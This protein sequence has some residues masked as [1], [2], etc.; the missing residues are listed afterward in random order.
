MVDGHRA[1]EAD[2]GGLRRGV[3][4]H[5][6]RAQCSDRGDIHDRTAI[7]ARNHRR[8]GVLGIEEH[9]LDIDAHDPFPLALGLLGD[10]AE[11]RNPDVVVENIKPPELRDCG[12]HHRR[13]LILVGE[14]SLVGNRRA[15]LRLDHPDRALGE[16]K[17]SVHDKHLGARARKENGRRTPI[18]DAVACRSAARDDGDLSI[19]S[20]ICLKTVVHRDSP[21][22][23]DARW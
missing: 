4:G 9:R 21:C 2:D 3:G 20:E 7:A 11:A 17:R 16:F 19:Q 1:G 18:A 6:A 23:R 12:L 13:A 22:P 14:V 15:A 8:D 10:R 5:A